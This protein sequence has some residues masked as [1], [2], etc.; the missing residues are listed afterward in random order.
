MRTA[1]GDSVVGDWFEVEREDREGAE[2]D[3][4]LVGGEVG[5]FWG[6]LDRVGGGMEAGRLVVEGSLGDEVGRGMRGGRLVVAGSVGDRLGM[7]LCGGDVVVVGDAGDGVG[8][9]E[10]G[11]RRGMQGGSIL[12]GGS[13][14]EGGGC[15]MRRGWILVGGDA[16]DELA[17]DMIAGSLV[18]L[19]WAKGR[20]GMGMRRG[21]IWLGGANRMMPG[22]FGEG[23][24][25][26]LSFASL[27]WNHVRVWIASQEEQWRVGDLIS[28]IPRHFRALRYV[29]D[30]SRRGMGEIFIS[31]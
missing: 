12:V 9:A 24:L 23:R 10:Y 16:G 4:V 5:G 26:E 31:E 1:L 25:S 8:E 2:M 22:R 20:V 13:I 21:T 28:R 6:W 19:G 18:V 30:H 29:G 14:G 17:R 15:A 7:G 3:M 27:F 11:V